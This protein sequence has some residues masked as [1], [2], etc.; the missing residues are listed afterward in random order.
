MNFIVFFKD[1]ILQLSLILFGLATIEIFLIAYPIGAFIKI[2]IP[3]TILGLYFISIFIEY[4]NKKMYY[5]N[6]FN[7]LYQLQEKYLITE[8]INKPNFIEGKILKE[9]MEQVDKSMLENVNK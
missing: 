3:L 1:K 6:I 7:V 2:Y 8:V 4:I 5:K 9:V